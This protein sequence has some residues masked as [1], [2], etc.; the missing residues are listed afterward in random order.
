MTSGQ[1]PQKEF[2]SIGTTPTEGDGHLGHGLGRVHLVDGL[3]NM[4]VICPHP[5]AQDLGL[6]LQRPANGSVNRIAMQC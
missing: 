5:L 6:Y 1:Q 4:P 2:V 3:Q